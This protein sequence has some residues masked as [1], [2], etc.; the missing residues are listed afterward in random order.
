MILLGVGVGACGGEDKI[1]SRAETGRLCL[2]DTA[3]LLP[4]PVFEAISSGTSLIR[5]QPEE[6]RGA[7]VFLGYRHSLEGLAIGLAKC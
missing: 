7:L 5:R 3:G 4:Y 6:M 1:K 2:T